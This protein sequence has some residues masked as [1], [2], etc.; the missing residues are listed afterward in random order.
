MSVGKMLFLIFAGLLLLAQLI[1]MNQSN[2]ESDPKLVLQ[3]SPEVMAIF[4]RSCYDCHSNNTQWPWYS[5]IAPAKWLITRD[6]EVGREWV[7]FSKWDSYDAA[8]KTKIKEQVA[9]AITHAMPLSIYVRAHPDAKLSEADRQVIR[10]WS[11]V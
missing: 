4:K 11:G 2:P 9:K 3:A 10:Q 7:N 5:K 8:R 1:P 6:V